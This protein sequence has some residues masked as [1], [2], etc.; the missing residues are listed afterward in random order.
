MRPV[1]LYRI[2]AV[3][4]V[5]FAVA[6]TIGFLSFKPPTPEGIAVAQG[7]KNVHFTV[8]GSTFSYGGFYE[9]FGLNATLY[10]LFSAFLAWQLGGLAA[11]GVTAVRPIAWGFF[12]VQVIGFVLSLVYFASAPAISSA[13]VAALVGWAAFLI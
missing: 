6:H 3:L 4:L 12:A 5:L 1:V 9:G 8:R 7:M 2:A 13:I 10:L 11:A